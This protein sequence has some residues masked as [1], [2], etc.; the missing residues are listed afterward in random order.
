MEKILEKL[1]KLKSLA[2]PKIKGKAKS[3][4]TSVTE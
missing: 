1:E 4:S 2:S 3:A